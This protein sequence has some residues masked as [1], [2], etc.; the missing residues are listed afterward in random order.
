MPPIVGLPGLLCQPSVFDGIRA[1][2]ALARM[3]CLDLPD[4]DSFSAIAHA[5]TEKIDH[6][7]ILVGMSMGSYLCFDLM[8]L[9]PESIAGLVLIGT[10][11]GADSP[12]AA[13]NRAKAAAWASKAGMDALE[14]VVCDQMLGGEARRNQAVR[15]R[16]ASMAVSTGIDTFARHQT[17]LAGR[18]D[19]TA[20]LSEIA[21]PV[22]VLTG[23]EDKVTPP[24][25]GQAVARGV[26]H[27]RF[28]PIAGAG[29]LPVLEAP[30]TVAE[31]VAN[32]VAAVR[33]RKAAA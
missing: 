20:R 4:V 26:R 23:E 6:D 17:A 33:Q 25:A 14:E 32:F 7:T 5:L 29:H 21:C 9:V 31:H 2:P 18:S 13:A 8:R 10:Q 19:A 11:S 12:E 28:I 30:S 15:D 24:A 27:G 22:L 1:H 16:I 3:R